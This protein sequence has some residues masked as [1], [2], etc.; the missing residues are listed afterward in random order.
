MGKNRFAPLDTVKLELSEGDWIEVKRALS[1]GDYLDL[2][3][4]STKR[5]DNDNVHLQ[6]GEFWINR[7]LTWAVDW[8]LEDERGKVELSHDAIRALSTEA[9][10]EINKVLQDYISQQEDSKN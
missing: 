4:A 5:D 6:M 8:S 2:Q 9:A 1:Y 10:A 7:L 3:D